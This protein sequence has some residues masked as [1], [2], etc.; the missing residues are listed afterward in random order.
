MTYNATYISTAGISLNYLMVNENRRDT[1]VDCG[2]LIGVDQGCR[3][4]PVYTGSS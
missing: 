1:L 4:E 3:P 2:G